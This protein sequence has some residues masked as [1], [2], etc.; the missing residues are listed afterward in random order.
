MGKT[1][2]ITGGIRSGKSSQAVKIA[3]SQ[4]GKIAFIAT[5]IPFDKEMKERVKQHQASRP[6]EWH[7]IEEGKEVASA[8]SSL[9]KK[10]DIA[11]IDCLGLFITNLL[12]DNLTAETIKKRVKL[13]VNTIKKTNLLTIIV[14][15]EVG[16]GLIPD[17]KLGRDFC[18]LLGFTNQEIAKIADEVILMVSGIPTKIKNKREMIKK[19]NRQ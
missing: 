9:E 4:E 5:A 16:L 17:N 10:Y 13:L 6:Q 15:N 1:I 12:L 18:D 8:L 11:L 3:H 2:L 14:S 19:R 7:L